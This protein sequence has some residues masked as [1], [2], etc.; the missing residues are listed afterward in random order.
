MGSQSVDCGQDFEGSAEPV[1]SDT[2]MVSCQKG[3]KK[4][5]P[6]RTS[7]RKEILLRGATLESSGDT[8]HLSLDVIRSH[9]I[10]VRKRLH[11][12]QPATDANA[13]LSLSITETLY[14]VGSFISPWTTA[15]APPN[16]RIKRDC[17]GKQA[18]SRSL[19]CRQPHRLGR[20][21]VH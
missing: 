11:S 5:V 13:H 3:S 17:R 1:V 15:S 7:V 21:T 10:S 19:R 16:Y 20:G 6:Y 8:P 4:C 12:T 9:K 14:A 18:P 2:V